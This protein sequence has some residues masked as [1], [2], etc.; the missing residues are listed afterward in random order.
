MNGFFSM[1][2]GDRA[3]LVVLAVASVLCFLPVWR[4]IE[5][6]GMALTGWLLAALMVLSPTIAL[7]RIARERRAGGVRGERR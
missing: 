3:Y 5:L 6:G 2:G 4:D 7:V 1:R